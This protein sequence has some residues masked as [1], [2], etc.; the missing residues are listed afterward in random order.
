ME[1]L[2]TNG[3]FLLEDGTKS[4]DAPVKIKKLQP[5][6]VK[7]RDRGCQTPKEFIRAML[8]PAKP[9]TDSPVKGSPARVTPAKGITAKDFPTKD[10]PAKKEKVGQKRF[11]SD[12]NTSPEKVMREV[13]CSFG[14][15][16]IKANQK[17][18]KK[19]EMESLSDHQDIDDMSPK[20]KQSKKAMNIDNALKKS[21]S[22]N[23]SKDSPRKNTQPRSNLKQKSSV[24]QSAASR[25]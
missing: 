5:P 23:L 11:R 24:N 1:E 6:S 25:K 19:I 2:K 16:Q 22:G 8:A 15:A 3:Y 4:S 12:K 9:R 18:R 20:L 10:S 14:E 21:K 7:T 17:K 13:E